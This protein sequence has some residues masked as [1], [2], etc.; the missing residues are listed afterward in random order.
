[1]GVIP[2][3]APTL[4]SGSA[5]P[6]VGVGSTRP[7]RPFEGAQKEYEP[8]PASNATPKQQEILTY[9]LPLAE[10]GFVRRGFEYFP[11]GAQGKAAMEGTIV[12][13]L[14]ED[15]WPFPQNE[16]VIVV[17]RT[18]QEFLAAYL[19]ISPT[20]AEDFL[21]SLPRV[22]RKEHKGALLLRAA[23]VHEATQLVNELRALKEIAGG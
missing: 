3:P 5:T 6:T 20:E 16:E 12:V 1:M 17:I 11:P 14:D 10:L 7:T 4:D 8:F 23:S 21:G 15:R 22:E 2:H 18:G 9:L 13:A 19:R